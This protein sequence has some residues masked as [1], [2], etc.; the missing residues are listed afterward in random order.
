MSWDNNDTGGGGQWDGAGN[1]F[2][3][4]NGFDQGN[5]GFDDAGPDGGDRPRGACYNCGEDG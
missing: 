1:N 5:T 3:D 4:T 2:G